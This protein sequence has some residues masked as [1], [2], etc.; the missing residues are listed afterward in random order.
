MNFC[1][2]L[3]D[4]ISEFHKSIAE[5]LTALFVEDNKIKQIEDKIAEGK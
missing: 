4:I 2:N 5:N 3:S 1:R